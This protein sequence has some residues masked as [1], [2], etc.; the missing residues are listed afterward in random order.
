MCGGDVICTYIS[1]A[2]RSTVSATLSGRLPPYGPLRAE[3][4][5]GGEV[6]V[7]CPR[8][9]CTCGLANHISTPTCR[10]GG[11]P[12]ETDDAQLRNFRQGKQY[13]N[14]LFLAANTAQSSPSFRNCDYLVS[15]YPKCCG[16]GRW[17]GLS[18][19]RLGDRKGVA[20]R[21]SP[22]TRRACA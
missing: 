18:S 6:E 17:S 14:I 19:C 3:N 5:R 9:R 4:Q 8:S 16:K 21:A 20:S 10:L 1:C 2:L 12:S 22:S 7:A 11:K 15:A 13:Q